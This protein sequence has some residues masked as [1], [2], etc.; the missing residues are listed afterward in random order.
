MF[1]INLKIKK[2][3]LKYSFH[4]IVKYTINTLI[5][6]YFLININNINII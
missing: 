2:N 3:N 1:L 4:S 6:L 5:L